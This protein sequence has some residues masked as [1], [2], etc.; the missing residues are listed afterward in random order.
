MALGLPHGQNYLVPHDPSWARLFDE[1]RWKLRSVLPTD[2]VDIQHIGSTAVP[3]LLAKPII[4]VAIAAPSYTLADDW[5][6]AMASLGYDYPGDIGIQ[7]HRIYGRD[8]G[9]RRFLVHVVD[10]GGVLW[11]QFLQF[12]DLLIA[13]QK[14]AAEYEA[15]KLAAATRYPTGVRSQYTD[16]KARYIVGVLKGTQHEADR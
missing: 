12:R 7:D 2:A 16:A 8:P 14:Q 4:D 11:R 1:E 6:D 13:D 15:V 10:A 5:Q 3:G 9:I